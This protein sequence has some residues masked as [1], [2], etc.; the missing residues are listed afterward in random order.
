MS[1]VKFIKVLSWHLPRGTGGKQEAPQWRQLVSRPSRRTKESDVSR[2]AFKSEAFPVWADM[3]SKVRIKIC[4]VRHVLFIIWLTM[5]PT[6]QTIYEYTASNSRTTVNNNL[7]MQCRK[8]VMSYFKATPR[9]FPGKCETSATVA[10]VPAE[11]RS[12]HPP[13]TNQKRFRL[14]QNARQRAYCSL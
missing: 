8:V 9:N 2:V 5:L 4:H 12:R 13:N 11:I 1:K 6:F 7:E 10:G 14:S 3:L